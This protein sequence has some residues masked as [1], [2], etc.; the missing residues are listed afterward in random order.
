MSGIELWIKG[1][2]FA[3]NGTLGH[4]EF[5]DKEISSLVVASAKSFENL[6]ANVKDVKLDLADTV[7]DFQ[8]HR[9]V[10]TAPVGR[11]TPEDFQ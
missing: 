7:K 5:I 10:S 8:I 1:L 6:G 9:Y 3:V 4:I 2:K 11:N